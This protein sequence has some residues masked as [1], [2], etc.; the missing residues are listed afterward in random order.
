MAVKLALPAAPIGN[1]HQFKGLQPSHSEIDF[2]Q[3]HFIENHSSQ[4]WQ[5]TYYVTRHVYEGIFTY[6]ESLYLSQV[7]KNSRRECLDAHVT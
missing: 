6:E 4:Q 5:T 3:V 7:V 1:F 2:A